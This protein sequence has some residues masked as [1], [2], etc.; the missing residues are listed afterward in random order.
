MNFTPVEA[1]HVGTTI[2]PA[3]FQN[4]STF[5]ETQNACY[6]EISEVGDLAYCVQDNVTGQL[7]YLQTTIYQ[8]D[9]KSPFYCFIR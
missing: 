1:G 8:L 6:T 2:L 5:Q 4:I 9:K 3:Y 7:K